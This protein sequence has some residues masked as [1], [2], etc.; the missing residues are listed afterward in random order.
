MS[1]SFALAAPLT[2]PRDSL[3]QFA[4][5][6]DGDN[7]AQ[8]ARDFGQSAGSM[9]ATVLGAAFPP[10]VP[11]SDWQL[12]GL[13]QIES[14][15]WRI[16]RTRADFL[17]QLTSRLKVPSDRNDTLLALRQGAWTERARIALRELLPHTLGELPLLLRHGK[18]LGSRRRCSTSHARKLATMYRI[19]S[20]RRAPPMVRFLNSWYWEWEN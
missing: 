8:L 3:L 10:F 14:D 16:P 18:S 13:A 4:R 15:G 12:K 1:V 17:A 9:V 6:L 11:R 2:E 20:V 7:A 5:Q 19:G